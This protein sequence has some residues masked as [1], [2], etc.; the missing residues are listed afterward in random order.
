M[1]SNSK[2]GLADASGNIFI[3]VEYEDIS[4]YDNGYKLKSNSKYGLADASGNIILDTKFKDALY[5]QDNLF[6]VYT[7]KWEFINGEG[8]VVEQPNNILLYTSKDGQT[9]DRYHSNYYWKVNIV[10]NTCQNGQGIMVL[11]EPI[12]SIG[13][14][15][16]YDCSRL[17]SVT[18]PNSVTSIGGWA[19]KG[20]TSLTSV[21]I[22]NSVT[23]I[24]EDAFYSC[25]N[26]TRVNVNIS[27]LARYCI[28]NPM[29]NI[30]GEKHLYLNGKEITNL[31]IPNGV[32]SIGG[33][34]F[35]SCSN[36]ISI[37]IPN[38]VTSIGNKA[39]FNCTSLKAVY[40]NATIPPYLGEYVFDYYGGRICCPIYVP[41]SSLSRYKG[42]G[43][44]WWRYDQYLRG[45]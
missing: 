26:L 4:R 39:F 8:K 6:A 20:C 9:I 28:S 15:A 27:D 12:T 44:N 32:T 7:N 22:G 38:S 2:Y 37:T 45:R 23:E 42:V 21:T 36:L 11:G 18:I 24:G 19:F 5:L 35:Y 10:S 43:G 14:L 30:P 29:H 3:P 40:L 17:T 31:V 13:Y 34:A 1:R 16:F 41:S 33:G 25:K